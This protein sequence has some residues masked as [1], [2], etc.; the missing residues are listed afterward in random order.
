MSDS[1]QSQGRII[2][3]TGPSGVGKGTL[4][5]AIFQEYPDLHFSVSATTRAPRPNETEGTHYYFL[6]QSEFQAKIKQNEFLEWAEFAG[7]YYGTPKAPILEKVK[8]GLTVILEIELEGA[9]H[10]RQTA[11]E[12]CQIFILPPSMEALEHRIRARGQDQPDAIAKRLARAKVEVA[13]A[14]EFDHQI[15]NDDLDRAR[16]ELENLIFST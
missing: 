9:R 10:V 14:H 8:E 13:A 2:V 11:P 16:L 7:N 12:A 1:L 3:I 5:Q 4:L 6:T 15:I